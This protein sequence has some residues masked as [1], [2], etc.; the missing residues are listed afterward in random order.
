MLHL[1][2]LRLNG[3]FLLLFLNARLVSSRLHI[4]RLLLPPWLLLVI[5]DML[6]LWRSVEILLQVI[7]LVHL[8]IVDDRLELLV[9]LPLLELVLLES[10][11]SV[12]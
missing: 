1:R 7:C 5:D 3:H 10:W 4:L 8:L 12:R 2:L 9:L 6:V 11:K